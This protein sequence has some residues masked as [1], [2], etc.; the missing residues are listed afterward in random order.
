VAADNP[1]RF[2]D[3]FVNGI[4]GVKVI[5]VVADKDFFTSPQYQSMLPPRLQSVISALGQI[6]TFDLTEHQI[7]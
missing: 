4:L 2:I 3:A 5:D 7:G 6:Q 1:V